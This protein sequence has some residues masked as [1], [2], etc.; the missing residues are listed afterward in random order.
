MLIP[1]FFLIA[2]MQGVVNPSHEEKNKKKKSTTPAFNLKK[3]NFN[4]M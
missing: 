3:I 2:F 1:M 4:N